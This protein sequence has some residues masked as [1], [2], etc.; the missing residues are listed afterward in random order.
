MA[1]L[2]GVDKMA[3]TISWVINITMEIEIAQT[4]T[5]IE[6]NHSKESKDLDYFLY[7]YFL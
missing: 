2:A 1:V 5:L 6:R 3:M 7:F 4:E